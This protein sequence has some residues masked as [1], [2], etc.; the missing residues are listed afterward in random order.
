MSRKAKRVILL[1]WDAADW[2]MIHP[3][4]DAGYMPALQQL[5]D[6]GVIGNIATLDPPLSPMLWTS[7]ATGKTADKHGILGFV[8]P[9]PNTGNIRPSTVTS[10]KVKALWN[11]LQQNNIKSHVVGWWPSHPAEP[12]DG[13]AVS[14][15]FSRSKGRVDEPWPVAENSV[16]PPELAETLAQCR[17]HPAELTW[18]HLMP[19]V[20]DLKKI[21]QEKDTR[22]ASIAV[23][24]AQSSTYHAAATWIMENREWEFLA[25]YMNE[26]DQFGHLF[27]KYHPPMLPDT[28]VEDFELFKGVMNAAYRFHDMML[29]RLMELAGEDTVFVLLSD[30]GF[31][32]DHLRPRQL[33]NDPAAPAHEHA[34]YGVLCIS[35]PGIR[36]D[37]RIYGATLLDIAPTVLTLFGIPAGED[38]DGRVLAQAFEQTEIPPRI[39][40]WENVE[41]RSGQHPGEFREDPWAAQEALKQLVELGYI[42]APGE[43]AEKTV[44]A[45]TLESRFYLAR[46]FLNTRR[47]AEALPILEE[48]HAQAPFI[49]RYT[50]RLIGCYLQLGRTADARNVVDRIRSANER[51]TDLPALD[52]LEGNLLFAEG[53]PRKALLALQRAEKSASHNPGVHQLIGQSYIATRNWRD[54]ERAFIRALA[55]DPDN[56]LAHHGLAVALL[57]QDKI[58]QAIDEALNAVGLL[59]HFPSAHYHLGEALMKAGMHDRAAE[60]FSLTVHLQ[61]GNSRAHHWLVKL[62]EGPL[63][64][65]EKAEYHRNFIM[66]HISRTIYIVSGMPR[67]G[68]SML[69]QMLRAGGLQTVTD[70]KRLSD[71]HNPQGYLEDDRVK[72]L[73]IDNTWL[74]EADG[75][76]VKVV[77]P[78]LQFLPPGFSYKI[79]YMHRDLHE[80]LQSQLKMTGRATDGKTFP[81]GLADAMAKQAEKAQAWM[82]AQPHVATLE[83]HYRHVVEDPADAADR[84]A[85]FVGENLDT[86]AMAAAV[87]AS[88]YRNKTVV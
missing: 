87:N 32:S 56:A 49:M 24:L 22:L 75:K 4:L 2:K 46:V 13:V 19:F 20:P 76:A 53:R 84:I 60:A 8:E 88:L 67:S 80:V 48:L 43:D 39:P 57:R 29:A 9:D 74:A 15:Q 34:P 40:S 70:D 72:R 23:L 17:V 27:M 59:H 82:K 3:L 16:H 81:A 45:V 52:V 10:R 37:D 69:M 26:I 65:H 6:N 5:I 86:D 18:A 85:A 41:G 50:L 51:H 30:H 36:K 38:M 54:A 7:I 25:L 58:E 11:I 47:P 12:I 66:N 42:E 64:N 21:D 55:I 33:P 68:T 73:H 1:G 44:K 28:N 61:P 31:H 79:I 62:Y 14:N 63:A 78:L 71:D 77:A 83:L 35:G